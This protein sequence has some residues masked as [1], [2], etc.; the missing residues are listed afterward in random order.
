MTGN[1]FHITSPYGTSTQIVLNGVGGG[2]ISGNYFDCGGLGLS[3][4]QGRWITG[5]W[6]KNL[7]VTKNNVLNCTGRP[8]ADN[9]NNYNI[10]FID[11]F[12]LTG[13]LSGAGMTGN[14]AT[15]AQFQDK[16]A[17]INVYN[18]YYGR[19]AY[20]TTSHKWYHCEGTGAVTDPWYND[21]G[22]LVYTPN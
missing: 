6:V 21:A 4:P 9:G 20:S 15:D 10:S 3:D 19:R 18:K 17:A 8:W 22:T 5:T 12:G 7:L 16:T 13:S 14:Y 1:I 11:N 2:I